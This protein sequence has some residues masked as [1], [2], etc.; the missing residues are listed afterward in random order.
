M[1]KTNKLSL[2]AAGLATLS[3][4]VASCGGSSSG[5]TAAPAPESEYP[6]IEQCAEVTYDYTAPAAVGN[7]MKITYDIAP[8]AVWEDGS[9]IT[10][11][12]FK[13]T[14]DATMNTPGSLSTS[15]Y[16][17]ITTIEAGSSDKQVVVTLKSVYAPWRGLFGG[18]IKAAS[19][20]NTADISGD[21]AE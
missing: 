18:L 1:K 13:A 2:L 5:D 6:T 12:D 16:D 4:V 15:G 17:Q 11:A 10:V 20:S 14:F 9:P 7:G 19:V 21:F 8:E 3:L